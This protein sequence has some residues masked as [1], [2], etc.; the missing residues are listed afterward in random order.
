MSRGQRL[1]ARE[2]C[3]PRRTTELP[4]TG[5]SYIGNVVR[6]PW[7]RTM[8]PRRSAS[9]R[10]SVSVVLA[11]SRSVERTISMPSAAV[12]RRPCGTR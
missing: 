9:V 1:R 7:L 6:S 5:S 11:S 8:A 10:I 3:A 12:S 4:A 2:G